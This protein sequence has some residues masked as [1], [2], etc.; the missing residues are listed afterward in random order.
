MLVGRDRELRILNELIGD[1]QDRGA[2]IVV[3]GDPG[4]GKSSL[5]R[6]AADSARKASLQLL[7][8]TGVEA[9]A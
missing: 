1:V 5:L 6:A 7:L 2:A 3:L 9:E 4:I 8:T